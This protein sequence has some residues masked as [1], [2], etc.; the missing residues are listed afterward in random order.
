MDLGTRG[1]AALV[2]GVSQEIGKAL[3]RLPAL[4][5]S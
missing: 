1:R 5:P 3:T 2:T 4:E